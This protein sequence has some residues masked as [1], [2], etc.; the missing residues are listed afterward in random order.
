MILKVE[1]LNWNPMGILYPQTERFA[2]KYFEIT[3]VFL[4]EI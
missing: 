3:S 2:F 4:F 1:L